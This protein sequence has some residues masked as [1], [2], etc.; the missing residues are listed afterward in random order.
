[1]PSAKMTR[2]GAYYIEPRGRLWIVYQRGWHDSR[3][4]S[5]HGSEQEAEARLR[6]IVKIHDEDE[7]E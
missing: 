4:I 2:I 5:S 6:E 7:G 1:M 3:E